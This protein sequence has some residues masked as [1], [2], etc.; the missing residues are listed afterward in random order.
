[1]CENFVPVLSQVRAGRAEY[2]AMSVEMKKVAV[3]IETARHQICG[4]VAVPAVSRLSDYANDPHRR[5]WAVTE[6]EVAELHGSDRTRKVGFLLIAAHE[7]TMISPLNGDAPARVAQPADY[8]PITR[9]P[10]AGL[11]T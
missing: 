10:L 5:F 1:M 9:D 3:V 4:N 8:E 7:I 11:L 2:R 6:A